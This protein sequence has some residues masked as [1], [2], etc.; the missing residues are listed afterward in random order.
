[1]LLVPMRNIL[2]FQARS[3]CIAIKSNGSI[4]PN[5]TNFVI[6][7]RHAVTDF[8]S[9]KTK[10]KVSEF[11]DR[12]QIMNPLNKSKYEAN[13]WILYE[14]LVD[15]IPFDQIMSKLNLPDTFNSWFIIT[16]LHLWMIFVR[17]MNEG[18]KGTMIRNFLMEAL[19]NDVE[20][21]SKKLATVSSDVR[22]RQI[23]EL[24]DQLRGALVGYDE[25]W[26]SNDM[27]LASMVWRRVFNKECNDPEQIELVV[28]YIR[29]QMSILQLQTFDSLFTKKDVKWIKFV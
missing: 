19:W 25:G 7:K 22:H 26:L 1:M 13:S 6:S 10:S 4:Y 29:K 5:N 3:V 17:L 27:V 8:V 20:F 15:Q 14:K 2:T 16:E 21:R 12:F 11:I 23:K 9:V 24:S 28:K 18:T